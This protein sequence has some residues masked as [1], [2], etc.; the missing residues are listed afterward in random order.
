MVELHQALGIT[1]IRSQEISDILWT[2]LEKTDHIDLILIG[3][4]KKL[5]G[6]ELLLAAFSLG[7]VLQQPVIDTE[8]AP[9]VINF[10]QMGEA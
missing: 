2:E 10:K 8:P 7:S 3:L 4:G 5:K 1:D 6:N 9:V